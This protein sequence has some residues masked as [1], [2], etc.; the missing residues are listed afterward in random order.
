[1]TIATRRLT[2]PGSCRASGIMAAPGTKAL[3]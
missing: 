3:S 2:D 1:M